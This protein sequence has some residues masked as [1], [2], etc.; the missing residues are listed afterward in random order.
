MKDRCNNRQGCIHA[1]RPLHGLPAAC[2]P[3]RQ[4]QT[5]FTLIELLV[6]VSIIALLVSILLPSL[7]Q[8]K[9]L[10]KRTI[11]ASNLRNLGLGFAMYAN[12]YKGRTPPTDDEFFCYDAY[13]V[14]GVKKTPGINRWAQHGLLYSL[15]YVENPRVFYCPSDTWSVYQ[16][17]WD[18]PARRKVTALVFREISAPGYTSEAYP[19]KT[20]NYGLPFGPADIAIMADRPCYN[21]CWHESGYNVLYL[22]SHVSWLSD[23]DHT[24]RDSPDLETA[25]AEFLFEVA[26]EA[27]GG[28]S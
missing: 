17:D 13:R 3:A 12:D 1:P 10:A 23:S 21:E 16:N 26:D 9:E 4:G 22:D 2:L 24:I 5:G 27:A 6:V 25:H 15:G 28:G 20:R 14:D 18:D 11:C 19:Y 7:N 8:A